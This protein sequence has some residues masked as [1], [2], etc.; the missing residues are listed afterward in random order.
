[1]EK[2]WNAIIKQSCENNMT[3]DSKGLWMSS[4]A[5]HTYVGVLEIHITKIIHF[6]CRSLKD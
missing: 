1:M 5:G 4:R 6:Q 2:N 3:L